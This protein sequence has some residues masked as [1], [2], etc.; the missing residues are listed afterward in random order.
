MEEIMK[1][2][3]ISKTFA[4]EL[5]D[6]VIREEVERIKKQFQRSAIAKNVISLILYGSTRSKEDFHKKSDI[7]L[8]LVLRSL[9]GQSLKVVRRIM[10]G[11]QNVDISIHQL[12]EII[13]DTGNITFQN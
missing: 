6:E 10:V 3:L 5:G 9:D 7:D 12:S 1:Q 2:K 11:C 4:W 8:H 13:S